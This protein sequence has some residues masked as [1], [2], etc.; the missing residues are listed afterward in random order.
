MVGGELVSKPFWI[1]LLVAFGTMIV[2]FI[3]GSMANIQILV[4]KLSP[5][6][7]EIAFL[8]IIVGILFGFISERMIKYRLS[9]K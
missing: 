6:Y 4:F 9:Q 7:T 5:T 3:I 2:L 1:P 8:P